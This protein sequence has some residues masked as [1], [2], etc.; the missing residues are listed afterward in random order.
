MVVSIPIGLSK[1]QI[2]RQLSK[3]IDKSQ[4]ERRILHEPVAK[5]PLLGTR[6]RKDR[7]FRYLYAVWVRR[8]MPRQSLWRVGARANV[9]DTLVASW[10]LKCG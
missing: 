5:Y 6:Q 7:L 9:G 1:A 3:L 10:T 8:R 2:T 4:E